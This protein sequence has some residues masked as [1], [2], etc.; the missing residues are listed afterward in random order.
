M[1]KVNVMKKIALFMM[2]AGLAVTMV[3]CQG[4]VGPQGPPG[5]DGD[6]G[7]DGP[8][9]SDAISPLVNTK[10]SDTF[11][12]NNV[13]DDGEIV[14]GTLPAAFD[15]GTYFRGGRGTLKFKDTS[16]GTSAIVDIVV[17]E[18][19]MVSF[20]AKEQ[21]D[22]IPMSAYEDGDEFKIQA[23]DED[24]LSAPEL[25]ITVKRNA[26]PTTQD[27][28]QSL[29]ITVGT[30]PAYVADATEET[31][32]VGCPAEDT[33][34]Y[35]LACVPLPGTIFMD[36]EGS[37]T[38][39]TYRVV[40]DDPAVSGEAVK[41]AAANAD[42][43]DAL[44]DGIVVKATGKPAAE[45]S[46]VTLRVY[47]IDNGNWETEVSKKITVTVNPAPTVKA[48]AVKS[49]KVDAHSASAEPAITGIAEQFSDNGALGYQAK[50]ANADDAVY[51]VPDGT[52]NADGWYPVITNLELVGKNPSSTPVG[53]VIRATESDGGMQWVEYTLMVTVE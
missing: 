41:Y 15:A 29:P 32:E 10:A 28:D 4:A 45:D 16:E 7:S 6:D 26:R 43:A 46:M 34:K 35:N 44:L 19:G 14:L 50:L 21:L 49:A 5:D 18:G 40:S 33:N 22:V 39:Y 47:A 42:A 2:I 9:G 17:T 37:D 52:A 20:T 30:Q 53:I 25:V 51:V 31:E 11:Y 12:I 8:P 1:E 48:T 23:T 27:A 24:D 36:N 38:A 3:A 13:V